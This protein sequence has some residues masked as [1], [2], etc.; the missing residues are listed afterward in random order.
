MDWKTRAEESGASERGRLGRLA[1]RAAAW[2]RTAQGTAWLDAGWI[3]LLTRAALVALTA[4]V[5]S[6]L[7]ADGG[8]SER[9]DPLHRWVTQ[10]GTH[11][12][13]IAAHGYYPI[14]RAM[15]WPLYPALEHVLGPVF[16]GDYGLAGL[17]I[18]N[19]S[20][21]GAL[22]AL[23]RLAE[24]ELGPDAAR[25]ATLYLAIFP[26]A[27]YLAAPYS[28]SLFLWM[29]IA[30]FGAMRARRWWLAG[31]LG[32]LATLTRSAG[33]LLAIPFAIEFFQAW[34]TGKSRLWQGSAV[35]LI[36]A[37]V[38]MYSGWLWRQFGDPLAWLHA[39]TYWRHTFRWPWQTLLDGI[40]GLGQVGAAHGAAGVHFLLNFGASLAFLALAVLVLRALPLSYG[41]YT[42]GVVLYMLCLGEAGALSAAAGDGRYVLMAFPAFMLLGRWG[43]HR[44]V[45]EA[46]LVLMTSLLALLTAHFLLQLASS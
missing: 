36:P 44:R 45:H 11:F 34:R 42:L 25:R 16:G 10:D 43:R 9:L 37:A 2:A 17:V 24:R 22:V 39:A 14:I 6:L 3:W 26:T 32:C 7:L 33:V 1:A 28:E 5:P 41:L 35:V 40:A 18:A 19:A 23:R 31:A 29:A 20:C 21:L 38:G 13:Y 12:A 15:M 30:S 27:F 46:L 8:A 4:L